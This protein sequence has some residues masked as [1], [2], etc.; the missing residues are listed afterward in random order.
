MLKELRKPLPSTMATIPCTL[1]PTLS[2]ASTLQQ[3]RKLLRKHLQSIKPP[4]R[5]LVPG[6]HVRPKHHQTVGRVSVPQP[7]GVLCGLP[8]PDSGIVQPGN[9]VHVGVVLL[10]NIVVWGVREHVVVYFFGGCWV[11]DFFPFVCS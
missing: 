6:A 9:Y 4:T 8:I 3:E 2:R 10:C 5:R 1:S 11:A 7:R